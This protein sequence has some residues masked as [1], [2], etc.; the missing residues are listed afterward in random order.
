MREDRSEGVPKSGT[1]ERRSELLK[2]KILFYNVAH[3]RGTSGKIRSYFSRPWKY[4]APGE[5]YTKKI[6][7]F[8]EKKRPDVACLVEVD[9]KQGVYVKKQSH[10]RELISQN[11]Y[12]KFSPLRSIPLFKNHHVAV[13]LKKKQETDSV[14]FFRR[15][16]KKTILVIQLTKMTSLVVCHLALLYRTRKKQLLELAKIVESIPHDVI[17]CGDFNIFKGHAEL[18]DFLRATNLSLVSSAATFP[19]HKPKHPLDLF[20]VSKKLA[21]KKSQSFAVSFSDHRPIM[22]SI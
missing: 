9:K 20:M 11:R 14:R 18:D 15:G 3:C 1:T 10:F 17:V 4:I 19:A 22:L 13:L 21:V 7:E 16:A 8:I 12:G 5:T 6:A 2:M